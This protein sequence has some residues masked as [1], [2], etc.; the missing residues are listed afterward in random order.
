MKHIF[1][2]EAFFEHHAISRINEDLTDR[3]DGGQPIVLIGHGRSGTTWLGKTLGRCPEALAYHEPC[4]PGWWSQSTFDVWFRYVPVD[5]SDA[6]FE[7]ALDGAFRGLLSP[8]ASWMDRIA[9]RYA[10]GYRVLVKEVASVMCLEWIAQRYRPKTCVIV[11][12]PCAV[13]LSEFRQGTPIDAPIPALL[14]QPRLMDEHL[15]PYAAVL[16]RARQPFEVYGAVWGARNRVVANAMS[17]HPE[18]IVVDYDEICA[19]PAVRIQQLAQTLGLSW[20]DVAST[21]LG[22][23]STRFVAGARE[24]HRI[25]KDQPG[26]WKRELTPEQLDQIR[27]FVEPFELPFY[28][29]SEW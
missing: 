7:R 22:E 19:D 10:P 20:D 14:K 17:R 8:G 4:N 23:T 24:I 25:T 26:K 21:F 9:R 2:P 16:E 15:A 11:R 28:S 13:A 3:N 27:R 5:G 1:G 12:H 18:F 29:S 6:Y